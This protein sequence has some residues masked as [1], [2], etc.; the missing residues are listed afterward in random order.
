LT[1]AMSS[2]FSKKMQFNFF[3]Q[4]FAMIITPLVH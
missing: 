3:G 1:R 2:G 4:Y